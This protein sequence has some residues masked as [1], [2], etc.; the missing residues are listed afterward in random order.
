MSLIRWTA[1]YATLSSTILLGSFFV[2]LPVLNSLNI[3]SD[4]GKQPDTPGIYTIIETVIAGA[5]FLIAAVALW[6]I[7]GKKR[8]ADPDRQR[9]TGFFF[10]LFTVTELIVLIARMY[11]RGLLTDIK[12][13]GDV[14]CR[15]TTLQ[16]NPTAR[17][18]RYGNEEIKTVSDC[19]FNAFN[20]ENI[21]GGDMIDWSK[22][23]NYDTATRSVLLQAI[24]SSGQTGIGLDQVPYYHPYWYWG[25]NSICHDR[26]KLNNTWVIL[27][28]VAFISYLAIGMLF[29]CS[30]GMPEVEEEEEGVPLMGEPSD[31]EEIEINLSPAPDEES[32][33]EDKT[34]QPSPPESN[35]FSSSNTSLYS[36]KVRLR[37]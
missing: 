32:D 30:A 23:V 35:P 19:V 37:M 33:D 21:D 27:S 3:F 10:I 15:D 36:T 9:L 25:C 24:I 20:T 16:G 6:T 2:S 4:T 1:M 18:E 26:F 29:Y 14:G 11:W 28:S 31:D 12:L 7:I 8:K 13:L 34:A 5:A 17:F 22:S